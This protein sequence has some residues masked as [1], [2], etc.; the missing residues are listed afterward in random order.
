MPLRLLAAGLLAVLAATGLAA[1]EQIPA[2]ERWW[3]YSAQLPGCDDP[4]VLDRIRSRFAEKE[5]RYW[6]SALEIVS[7][8]RIRTTAFRP[9]GLDLIPRRYCTARVHLNNLRTSALHYS[10]IED[11]GMAGYGFGVRFC[12]AGYDRNWANAPECK[13]ARP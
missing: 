12:V 10:V 2:E 9:N 6:H 7:V 11:A 13:M 4:A 8:D 3:P 1:R 5:S